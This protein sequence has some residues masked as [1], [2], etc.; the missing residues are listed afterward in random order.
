MKLFRSLLTLLVGCALL[1]PLTLQAEEALG[2]PSGTVIL[3][4]S[5]NIAIANSGG[6]ALF[7]RRMLEALPQQ[8]ITTHTPWTEGSHTYEGVSLGGLLAALGARGDQVVARALDDF[9]ASL[10][11]E[12]I[13]RYSVLL[14]LKKD[15]K[16]MRVRRKGPLWIIY[17]LSD[18]PEIDN[19]IYHDR[20]VWQL[21]SI[22]VN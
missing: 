4:V 17:P 10:S 13:R 5:G 8:H 9:S 11:M 22:E 21:K 18:H 6:K 15:G 19:V 20:M 1:S 7:D 12:E 16:P 3:T 14:A 2:P